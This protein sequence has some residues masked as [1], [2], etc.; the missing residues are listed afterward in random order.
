MAIK[1]QKEREKSNDGQVA[2]LFTFFSC[3]QV[4]N[5]L[6]TFLFHDI[7]FFHFFLRAC[8]QISYSHPPNPPTTDN[9]DSFGF[10][11]FF[12]IFSFTLK[13]ILSSAS[14]LY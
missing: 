5:V 11:R 3:G 7:F 9:T 10:S 8:H 1:D 14:G 4:G 13:F 6:W 2:T 12:H